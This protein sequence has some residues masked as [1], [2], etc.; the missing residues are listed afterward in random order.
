MIKIMEILVDREI[1]LTIKFKNLVFHF[2]KKRSTWL[3]VVLENDNIMK[4]WF[5]GFL[6]IYI[7][8]LLIYLTH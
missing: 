7:Q 8:S 6:S 5:W 4:K 2:Q 3:K 1:F